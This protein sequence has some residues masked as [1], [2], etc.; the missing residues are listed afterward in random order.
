M[1]G[2]HRKKLATTSQEGELPNTRS[3]HDSSYD[4]EEEAHGLIQYTH[5]GNKKKAREI[6]DKWDRG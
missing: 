3:V 5:Q 6:L 4:A 1:F 2:F